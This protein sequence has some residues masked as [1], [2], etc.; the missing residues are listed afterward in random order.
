MHVL[1]WAALGVVAGAVANHLAD[2]L[3]RHLSLRPAPH[4]PACGTPYAA[5]QRL[6]LLAWAA[7][8]LRCHKCGTPLAGRRRLFEIWLAAFFAI[9]AWRH[10]LSWWLVAASF[11][12]TVLS[13]VAITDLETRIVPNLAIL[14]AMIVSLAGMALACR[15]CT[16]PMLLGGAVGFVFFFLLWAVYPKGMGFGDVKLAGYVG[17]IAGYPRVIPCLLAAILAGG[18]TA[19]VLLVSRRVGRRTYIPYAPFLAFGGA[20]ALFLWS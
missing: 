8:D 5:R 14:P 12:A 6:A 7:H 9:L 16:A 4:C 1:L 2:R 15:A 11:H 20:L 19:L 18:L 3:P 13:V 17:L 10:G